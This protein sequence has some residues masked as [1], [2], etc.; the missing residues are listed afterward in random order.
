MALQVEIYLKL[1]VSIIGQQNVPTNIK[2]INKYQQK[3][4]ELV[5]KLKHTN[6]HTKYSRGGGKVTQIICRSEI[7]FVQTILQNYTVNW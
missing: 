4:K 1:I 6:Y 5:D 3:Y 7:L 2:M